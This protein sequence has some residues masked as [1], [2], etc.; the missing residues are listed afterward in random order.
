M[1]WFGFEL[2][3]FLWVFI[4]LNVIN[5]V[6]QTVK[7]IVTIS[8][9]KMVAAVVNAITFAFYTVVVIY[10]NADGLGIIW[11]AVIIGIAN[12]GGVYV[13]K[14]LEERMRKDKLWKVEATLHSQGIKPEYDDCIIELRENKIPFNYID[15]DKYIIVNCY[16]ETQKESTKVKTILDKYH[17]KYF[18]SESKT[19]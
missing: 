13:V 14:L 6:I 5:V 3:A 19:L 10:M 15:A 16:C 4:V 2:S 11:K 1:N 7:S 17:A 8:G 12:F 9:T 18:A